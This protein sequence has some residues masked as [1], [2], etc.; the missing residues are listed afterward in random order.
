MYNFDWFG[1]FCRADELDVYWR[2]ERYLA[3]LVDCHWIR[4]DDGQGMQVLL[5][6]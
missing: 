6:R 1:N 4:Q 3:S 5:T 2:C